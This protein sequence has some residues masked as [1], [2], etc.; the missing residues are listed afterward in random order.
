MDQRRENA[1][2]GGTEYQDLAD[3]RNMVTTMKSNGGAH[4][5]APQHAKP[6][7][8]PSAGEG[9][10]YGAQQAPRVAPRKDVDTRDKEEA[11]RRGT[12]LLMDQKA[13]LHTRE[14]TLKAR[15]GELRRVAGDLEKQA[16]KV[17]DQQSQLARDRKTLAEEE[18][19]RRFVK[20]RMDTR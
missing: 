15:E 7:T 20:E 16:R 13:A 18:E 4:P 5:P 1:S 19:G 9:H 14:E 12:Q 11:L 10:L 6:K 2:H 8:G 17:V 3:I